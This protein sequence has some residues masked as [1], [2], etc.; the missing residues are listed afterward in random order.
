MF[1]VYFGLSQS[2]LRM[3]KYQL[4]I[5]QFIFLESKITEFD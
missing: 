5:K 1:H 4:R 2:N 3:I